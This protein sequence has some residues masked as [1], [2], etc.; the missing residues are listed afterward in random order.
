M[1]TNVLKSGV[2]H[3]QFGNYAVR[4]S[5]S[6][7]TVCLYAIYIYIYKHFVHVIGQH[8]KFKCF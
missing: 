5:A 8:E 4:S 7:L 3:K 6:N 2:M 1:E